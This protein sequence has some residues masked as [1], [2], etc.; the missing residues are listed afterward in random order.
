MWSVDIGRDRVDELYHKILETYVASL[1]PDFAKDM[2]QDNRP[3]GPTRVEKVPSGSFFHNLTSLTEILDTHI[4]S[5]DSDLYFSWTVVRNGLHACHVYISWD[6]IL[7]RPYLPPTMTHSP[8]A[9]AVQ[10]IYM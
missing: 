3:Q 5:R 6:R 2:V 9:N 7:I 8:F 10:R 4:P 1:P